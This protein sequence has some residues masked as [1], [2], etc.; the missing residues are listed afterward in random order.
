MHAYVVALS[1]KHAAG[2]D[3]EGSTRTAARQAVEHLGVCKT[4]TKFEVDGAKARIPGHHQPWSVGS[5]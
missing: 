3:L 5:L 1:G 4:L 2:H